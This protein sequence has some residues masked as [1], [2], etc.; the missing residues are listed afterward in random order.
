MSVFE[1]VF[2]TFPAIN[3]RIPRNDRRKTKRKI[4]PRRATR[5][6][7]ALFASGENSLKRHKLYHNVHEYKYITYYIKYIMRLIHSHSFLGWIE[8]MSFIH[9]FRAIRRW[10]TIDT[11][12]SDLITSD[13][14]RKNISENFSKSKRRKD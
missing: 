3:K 2:F 6:S 1:T 8:W 4:L 7:L 10:F 13:D 11:A 12:L 9:F 5:F 14:L